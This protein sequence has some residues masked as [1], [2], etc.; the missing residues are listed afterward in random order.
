MTI[1]TSTLNLISLANNTFKVLHQFFSYNQNII[2]P[3]HLHYPIFLGI[4]F[5][6][7]EEDLKVCL[8]TY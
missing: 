3:L 8:V 2:C 5:K 7:G 6:M 1:F 4:S